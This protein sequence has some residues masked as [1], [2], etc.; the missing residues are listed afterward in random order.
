MVTKLKPTRGGGFPWLE[1]CWLQLNVLLHPKIPV[2]VTDRFL[3][4]SKLSWQC[5]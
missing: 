1:P 5:N 3:F 2:L 4:D